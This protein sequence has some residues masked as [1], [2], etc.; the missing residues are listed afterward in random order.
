MAIVSPLLLAC[1]PD[2]RAAMLAHGTERRF[3]AGEVILEQGEEADTLFLLEFGRVDVF[4]RDAQGRDRP[5]AEVGPGEVIGEQA[6]L[7]PDRR[8]RNASARAQSDVVAVEIPYDAVEGV[9]ERSDRLRLA[10]M[11]QSSQQ[12]RERV[13]ALLD[14]LA[15]DDLG[16]LLDAAEAR[17]VRKGEVLFAQGD[18]HEDLLYAVAD[19]RIVCEVRNDLSTTIVAVL[20]AGSW[21]GERSALADVPRLV[22]ATALEPTTVL[23]LRGAQIRARMEQRPSLRTYFDT[24][25]RAYQT[26][27]LGYVTRHEVRSE[28]REL[29]TTYQ[30][31]DGRRVGCVFAPFE[32]AFSAVLE[33]AT[34]TT[35]LAHHHGSERILLQLDDAQRVCTIQATEAWSD[36]PQA[37]RLLL[38][39]VPL[40][41]W[42]AEAFQESGALAGASSV[43]GR[44]ATVCECVG[45]TRSEILAVV[46]QGARTLEDL[47]TQLGCGSVC[48]GC[49]PRL[50]ELLGQT[51]FQRAVIERVE[52]IGLDAYRL[53]IEHGQPWFHRLGQHVVLRARIGE[54]SRER[55]YTVSASGPG[56]TELGVR[57]LRGGRMS[58]WLCAPDR[59]GTPIAITRPQGSF[60]WN[61]APA[62]A[63]VAGIGVTVAASF[64]SAPCEAPL[65]VEYVCRDA[66]VASH[67]DRLEAFAGSHP[68]SALHVHDTASAGRPATSHWTAL[69]RRFRERHFYLCGPV[70]F[71]DQVGVALLRAGVPP[72]QVHREEFKPAPRTTASFAA[73]PA[74][75]TAPPAPVHGQTRGPL[76][77]AKAFVRQMWHERA[78]PEQAAPRIG[79]IEAEWGVRATYRHTVQ[80]LEAGVRIAWRNAPRCIGR[81]HWDSIVVR[82]C[83]HLDDHESIAA[84]LIEHIRLATNGGDLVPMVSV[85]APEDPQGRSWRIWNPQLIR[86]AGYQQAGGAVLGDPLQAE[87]TQRILELGWS[88]QRRTAFDVLPIVVQSPDGEARWFEIPPD[89]VLQVPIAHP[90]Y[91]WFG[92]LGLRWYALPA[93]S[94][95]AL[96]IGGLTYPLAPFNGWYMST[97]ISARNFSDPDRYDMLYAVASELGLN[98]DDDASLWKDRAAL[99]LTRAVTSSF[100]DAGVRIT[101]HH[102]ASEDFQLFVRNEQ[103]SGRP[104]HMRW[105]WIVPPVG[106]ATTG[107]FF[108]EEDDYPDVQRLPAILPQPRAW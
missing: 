40:S 26:A 95:M 6:L 97:E 91:P 107:V 34:P 37:M 31:P 76:D 27:R 45:S 14:T 105:S 73:I 44:D 100:R 63:I 7:R 58:E 38:D 78:Q 82:D 47:R 49:V 98:T 17:Q 71:M 106:G 74:A 92:D 50:Q 67:I 4:H 8:T 52:R 103:Q 59:P 39:G 77:E 51:P 99:E 66:R 85:F 84:S 33:G 101:D 62:V 22:T 57:R 65:H 69:A 5:I 13:E 80:E 72:S 43:R 87:L 81:L 88:P 23:V 48:G 3:S 108:L 55:S 2:E 29:L 42:Q 96:S 12:V 104:V 46:D 32:R 1:T 16:E 18:P 68:G 15:P 94:E 75:T 86:Y 36:L 25:E 79:E 90:E 10:L 93:V 70:S 102:Q 83:R 9:L 53:V 24:L 56:W 61:G 11:E 20:Q 35:T 28:T 41:S 64:A 54:R 30:L 60:V 19:G 89:A 21:L